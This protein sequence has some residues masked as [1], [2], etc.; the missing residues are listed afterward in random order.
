MWRYSWDGLIATLR[1]RRARQTA[2]VASLFCTMLCAATGGQTI[3]LR[4]HTDWWSI[5]NEGFRRQD[6]KPQNKRIEAGNFQIAGAAL[7]R[8]QFKRLAARLGKAPVVERGDAST[9]R[10]QVCY[11]SAEDSRRVHL[12]FEFGE[13]ESV[14]YL[15][16]DGA[17]WKG[18]R[19]CVKTKQI[20]MSS[21]TTSGL[22][23][24]L[25][26]PQVEAI[27]GK[28][29][30]TYCNRLVFCR[31]VREK[32]TPAQFERQRKEYP[33]QL[34]DNVAHEQFDFYSVEIY[35]EAGFADLGMNYLAVSRSGVD[36]D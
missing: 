5:N 15:F 3:R 22:K 9:G 33:V 6:V 18:S 34:S 31:E 7:G 29:D 1:S 35:I 12:I 23:L 27:L 30:T 4:D 13:D 20:S 2:F 36:A 26:R 25:A 19:L 21:G 28:P 16:S 24:G 14:F 17:D 11:V 8:D 32:R 10:H